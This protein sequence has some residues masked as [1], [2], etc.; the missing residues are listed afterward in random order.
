MWEL[1]DWVDILV[2]SII[3]NINDDSTTSELEWKW[4]DGIEPLL[5]D[6]PVWLLMWNNMFLQTFS[7]TFKIP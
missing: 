7:F 4:M 5:D 1:D 6:E 2:D 3:I